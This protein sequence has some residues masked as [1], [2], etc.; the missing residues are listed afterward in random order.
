MARLDHAAWEPLRATLE[1]L[2]ASRVAQAPR[3]LKSQ[4]DSG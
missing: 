4:V 2:S 1:T 3:T